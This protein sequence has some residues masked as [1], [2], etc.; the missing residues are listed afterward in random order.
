[1]LRTQLQAV[2]SYGLGLTVGED[3][4]T[5]CDSGLSDS[6]SSWWSLPQ[7]ETHSVSVV[8]STHIWPIQSPKIFPDPSRL[9]WVWPVPLDTHLVFSIWLFSG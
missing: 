5:Y 7:N 8:A 2:G 9:M 1:M 6:E 3:V 4:D